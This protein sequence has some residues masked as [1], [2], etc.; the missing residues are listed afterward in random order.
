[1]SRLLP[2]SEPCVLQPCTLTK[3][4]ERVAYRERQNVF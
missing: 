4:V 3:A 1:M 2:G